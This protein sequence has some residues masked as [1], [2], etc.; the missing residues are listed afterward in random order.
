M[1]FILQNESGPWVTSRM[2]EDGLLMA[3]G[4]QQWFHDNLTMVNDNSTRV[5]DG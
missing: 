4:S 5:H 1:T 3:N 2:V